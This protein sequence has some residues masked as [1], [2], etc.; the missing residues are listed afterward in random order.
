MLHRLC[1]P[2]L[3]NWVIILVVHVVRFTK[4]TSTS[5]ERITWIAKSNIREV[6]RE[7]LRKPRAYRRMFRDQVRRAHLRVVDLLLS[8]CTPVRKKLERCKDE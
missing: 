1:K 5:R 7:T 8:P 6:E 4:M 3:A 2:L